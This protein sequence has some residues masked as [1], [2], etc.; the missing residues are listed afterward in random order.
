[1]CHAQT[2]SVSH[3][4]MT[5][6]TQGHNTSHASVQW[7]AGRREAGRQHGTRCVAPRQRGCRTQAR[8]I[9]QEGATDLAPGCNGRQC[10]ARL[11]GGVARGALRLRDMH[12]TRVQGLS[13]PSVTVLVPVPGATV[14]SNQREARRQPGTRLGN[15]PAQG[16]VWWRDLRHEAQGSRQRLTSHMRGSHWRDPTGLY[17]V[18]TCSVV[19]QARRESPHEIHAGYC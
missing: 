7:L 18:Y 15:S 13:H 1:V 16:R 4:G 14:C 5:N 12:C 3:P 19:S 10:S 6:L 11:G 2:Q 9:L 8:R 17:E